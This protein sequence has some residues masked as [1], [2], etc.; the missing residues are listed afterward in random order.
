VPETTSTTAVLVID[1]QESVVDGCLDV[2]GV[3]TRIN[4]LLARAREAGAPVVFIQNQ[5]PT[6]PTMT[7]GSPGWEL[8]AALD[9]SEGDI[10]VAKTYRD[11]FADTELAAI[12]D[13]TETERLVVTGAHSD[14]CVQTTAM[15]AVLRGFDVTLVS[16]AHT[17]RAHVLSTGDLD[18]ETIVAFVNSRIGT[19]TYPGRT[20][21]VRSAADVTI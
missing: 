19:L 18:P 3:I 2:D 16:D 6:D 20:V 17:A 14:F 1:M 10:V 8:A 13:K 4:G 12:L 21:N 7:A 9:R 11:S 15:A 5:D